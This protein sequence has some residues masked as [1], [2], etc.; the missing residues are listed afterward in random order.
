VPRDA[1][2]QLAEP[3][4]PGWFNNGAGNGAQSDETPATNGAAVSERVI[5]EI[6]PLAA[7]RETCRRA[8]GLVSQYP[9]PTPFVIRVPAQNLEIDFPNHSVTFGPELADALERL[10]GVRRVYMGR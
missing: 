8:L 7:W 6:V 5:F 1:N 4:V 2:G 10:P 3:E 9:G